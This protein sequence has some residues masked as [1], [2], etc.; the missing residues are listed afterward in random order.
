MNVKQLVAIAGVVLAFMGTVC[1]TI[2]QGA[3]SV[4]L[5]KSIKEGEK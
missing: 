4:D 2:G 3:D 1:Q 5:I